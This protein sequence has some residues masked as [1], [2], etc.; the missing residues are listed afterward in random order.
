MPPSNL[1]SI[2]DVAAAWVIRRD[3][4]LSAT[5][6]AEYEQ[7]LR[8]DPRHG[9]AMARADLVWS[10]LDPVI[11][12]AAGR[13]AV[14][15]R[16][17]LAPRTRGRRAWLALPLLAAAAAAAFLLWQPSAPVTPP[18][19]GRVVVHPAPERLKLEDGSVVDLNTGAK[20]TVEFTPAERRVHLVHG[21]AF[22]T[23]A[24][25]PARPFIVDAGRVAVRA[26]GTAFS[27]D[28]GRDATSVLVTEGRVGVKELVAAT[29]EQPAS[30]H[31]LAALAAGQKGVVLG[32]PGQAEIKVTAL[33]PAQIERALA[34]QS[35]RLE[36]FDRPLG[37]VVADFNRYNQRKLVVRDP[38]TAGVRI[39]GNFRADN[40][41]DFVRLLEIGF[42]ISATAHGEEIILQRVAKP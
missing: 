34:W 23:V 21:E 15:D 37:D 27:V 22:F 30:A 35:L 18:V 6:Q 4:G 38:A 41:D 36:F 40:V 13:G 7:W 33:T 19:R 31:E 42:D 11:A 8:A 12:G 5:E 24:K 14:P 32:A 10:A 25:N 20:V 28:L 16:D 1:E 3:R 29:G 17:L 9:A 26:I 39:G 2:E